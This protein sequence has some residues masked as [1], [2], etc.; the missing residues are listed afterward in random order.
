MSAQDLPINEQTDPQRPWVPAVGT[1]WQIVLNSSLDIDPRHPSVTPD[2]EVFNIDLFDNSAQTI[3]ALHSLN[4]KV[5]CYFSAGTFEEWRPDASEFAKSDLG[6]AMDDWPGEKWL[7]LRSENVRSIMARRIKLAAEKG[8]DGID[9]DNVDGYSN[10]NGV[11]LKKADSIDFIK[12]LSREA[13]KYGLSIGLKNA[14]E[15][16]PDVIDVVDFQVNEECVKYNEGE[17]FGAFI[18]AGKAVFHIEYPRGAPGSVSA[19]SR[20]KISGAK[21]TEGFSTLLKT[22]DLDGWVQ[23]CDGQQ[24]TTKTDSS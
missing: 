19:K 17:T 4:K 14:G 13:R 24:F 22:M 20:G 23:F 21:G 1:S 15:I 8:C 11:G 18:N 2:V 12:F 16:I 3:A 10:N 5:I 6:K 9:P 7:D